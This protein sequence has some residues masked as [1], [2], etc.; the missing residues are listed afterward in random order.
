MSRT[1]AQ[2]DAFL[3]TT[4]PAKKTEHDFFGANCSKFY[5]RVL[6]LDA[7]LHFARILEARASTWLFSRCSFF[8]SSLG[9][10]Q[11]E[12]IDLESVNSRARTDCSRLR[13]E[14][15][16][17]LRTAAALRAAASNP[18][19]TPGCRTGLLSVGGSNCLA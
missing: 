12:V 13:R 11:R 2:S 15:S 18:A 14:S 6:H 19:Q 5:R 10:A 8:V 17:S 7:E 9:F 4:S 1:G 3:V 16:A